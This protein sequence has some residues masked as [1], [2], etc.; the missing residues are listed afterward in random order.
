MVR[1]SLAAVIGIV[2]LASGAHAQTTD[3]LHNTVGPRVYPGEP[4]SLRGA[5]DEA[6]RRNLTL[7]ALQRQR[8]TL[9]HRPAQERSLMPPSLEAQIWQ[10]PI[11]T[12]NPLNT[13]M[14]MF[15]IQQELPGRGKRALRAAVAETE[16]AIAAAEIPARARE[17]AADVE[18]AYADLAL[19]RRSIDIHVESVALLRQFADV[20]AVKYA[21]GRSSQQDV[22]KAIVELSR[23][24][25][26][27]VIHEEAAAV[28]AA[29]LNT[30]LDRP[31]DA[32]IGP[33]DQPRQ[34]VSLP[35]SRDLQQMAIDNHPALTVALLEVQRA[36][37]ERAVV[38][39][40]A[41]PDFFV[42]GGYMLMPR[43]A[44]A[45]TASAGMTW[46]NAPWSRRR[47]AAR[48][49]EAQAQVA[50]E[51]ARLEELER[52]LRLAVHEAYLRVQSADERVSLFRTTVL[53]QSVQALEISRVAYQTERVGFMEVLDSQRALLETQLSYHRAL[54]D[55]EL[56]VAELFRSVGR[57]LSL[58]RTDSLLER[59]P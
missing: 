27:L 16:A 9:L 10:W 51:R 38:E 56:A 26:D 24:H 52:A 13:D 21:A 23:L 35:A 39:R 36:E 42:G 18:R 48:Q 34:D 53:P 33:V 55:R 25:E 14:Y 49:A 43:E 40:D 6:L 28:A 54:A 59:Q 1:R 19:A 30:L 37:A 31:P 5:V 11:T 20:S 58:A 15:M 22:L 57:D 2:L 44:G 12:A 47:V 7:T 32:L 45:W 4:L 50:A 29:R 46:P 3:H 8:E 41:K 17:V